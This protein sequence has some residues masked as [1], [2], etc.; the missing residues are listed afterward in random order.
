[1]TVWQKIAARIFGWQYV[2]WLREL[3]QPE[4][5]RA[6]KI[7]GVYQF[8]AIRGEGNK[9]TEFTVYLT[10]ETMAPTPAELQVM[11]AA[12]IPSYDPIAIRSISWAWAAL[13]EEVNAY[14]T[15]LP[16]EDNFRSRIE[17]TTIGTQTDRVPS[18]AAQNT[19][20]K[21][22]MFPNPTSYDHR[23]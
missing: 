3:N 18:A 4:I 9:T 5:H 8:K 2:L 19:P 22:V 14:T 23:S 6:R 21:Q 17:P 1:M 11:A 16:D 7:G 20:K 10:K 15:F 13:T 12:F